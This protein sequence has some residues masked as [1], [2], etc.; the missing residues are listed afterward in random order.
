MNVNAV[1]GS[2][3]KPTQQTA[4]NITID[5]DILSNSAS[6]VSL[7]NVN[8]IVGSEQIYKSCISNENDNLA[9]LLNVNAVNGSQANLHQQTAD[10]V[11]PQIMTKLIL[12]TD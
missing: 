2:Q 8:T 12:T 6:L 10:N 3:A 9:S 7:P 11:N 1:D 4:V 5:N